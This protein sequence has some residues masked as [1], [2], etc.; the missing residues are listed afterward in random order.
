MNDPNPCPPLNEIFL[1]RLSDKEGNQFVVEV[2]APSPA[3]AMLTA[4]DARPAC[5]A[6]G[7]VR[8]SDDAA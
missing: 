4:E 8:K 1:V 3:R 5:L 2:A 6:V 7:A